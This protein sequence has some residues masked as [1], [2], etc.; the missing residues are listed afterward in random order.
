MAATVRAV[1]QVASTSAGS[2][3]AAAPAGTQVGD[4]LIAIHNA[5]KGDL[6]SMT[7]PAAFTLNG[8][9][10]LV[11]QW[12]QFAQVWL[13]TR[14]SAGAGPYPFAAPNAADGHSVVLIAVTG[15]DSTTPLAVGATWNSSASVA[16]AQ[17]APS[18]SPAVTGGLLLCGWSSD[19]FNNVVSYTT[20]PGMTTIANIEGSANYIATAAASQS[21]ASA[22]ATGT[23]TATCSRASQYIAVSLVVASA[24]VAPPPTDTSTFFPFFG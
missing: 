23:R 18:V 13:A 3:S 5:N 21:L 12:P 11:S 9:T 19:V 2:L 24:V 4:L 6:A 1:T 15:Y 8:S 10:T 16:T 17:V 14:A 20:P 22:G 7:A